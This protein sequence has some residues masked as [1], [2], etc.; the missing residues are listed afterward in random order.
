MR[1]EKRVGQRLSLDPVPVPISRS[2]S[3]GEVGLSEAKKEFEFELLFRVGQG[4][5]DA[6]R[7]ERYP[8][9]PCYGAAPGLAG[10]D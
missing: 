10:E 1:L 7:I 3:L 6:R 4:L 8:G 2:H 5:P 9:D